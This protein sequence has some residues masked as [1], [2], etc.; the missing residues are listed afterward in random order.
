MRIRPDNESDPTQPRR[1]ALGIAGLAAGTA[2]LTDG[3]WVSVEDIVEGDRVMTFE[4]GP[5]PVTSIRSRV[6]GADISTFWPNGILY[7]PAGAL[8]PSE[9]FYLL[10]G[11]HVM[12]PSD[13]ARAMTDDAAALVPAAALAGIRGICRVMPVDLLE[14]FEL[15]LP[16]EAAVELEGGTWARCPGIS[17]RARSTPLRRRRVYSQAGAA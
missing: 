8:G 14:V 13:L 3:G 4:H 9:A 12:L 15:R 7:V 11:Q 17:A 6:F 16:R 5:Q 10:P 1:T 2:V